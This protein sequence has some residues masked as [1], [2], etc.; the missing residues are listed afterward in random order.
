MIK[1]ISKFLGRLKLYCS[2]VRIK[3]RKD[4]NVFIEEEKV[5]FFSGFEFIFVF[6]FWGVVVFCKGGKMGLERS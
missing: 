6:I 5:F 1:G 2:F 3:E 4:G